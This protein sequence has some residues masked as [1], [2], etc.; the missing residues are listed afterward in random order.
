MRKA[1]ALLRQGKTPPSERKPEGEEKP[2]EAEGQEEEPSGP[3][4]TEIEKSCRQKGFF[5][6]M[7]FQDL[8]ICEPLKRGLAHH[9]YETLT[10]IQAKCIPHLL[11]G[12]DLLAAAG[13]GSGKSLAFLV[14]ALEL[15]HRANFRYEQGIA[16]IV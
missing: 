9:K 15:L 6:E 14:P 12:R 10:E 4:V 16:V 1:E 13:T 5:T 7:R 8:K 11:K 2:K 3:S